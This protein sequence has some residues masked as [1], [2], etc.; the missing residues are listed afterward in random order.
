MP[1]FSV[2]TWNINSVRLRQ[3]LV[4]Q[5]MQDHAP[6][7]VCL[8]E[9]KCLDANFPG[10]AFRKLGYE[11][12][13][14][15]G[16]KG[17]HGVAV[18]SKLPL[19]DPDPRGF[20]GKGDARHLGVTVATPLGPVRIDNFYVPAGGDIPD[21]AVNDKFQHKLDFLKEMT[22][23]IG[24]GPATRPSIVV[25]DLNIAPL[26]DDVWSHKQLLDVVSHTPVETEALEAIRLGGQ[27]IDVLRHHVPTP[28]RLYTWWSY[29]AKDWRAA[30]KGR[31]L[32]HIWASGHFAGQ[33]ESLTVLSEARGWERPS[34]HVPVI[35]RFAAA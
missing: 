6:D 3:D 22:D 29:R 4:G 24:Q 35:A 18:L 5:L 7:V 13:A 32:D 34:D 25:G 9:T 8:Q 27:W 30:N 11:H 20:C 21:P 16:Q 33:L 2:A 12:Q 10:A 23:W 1:R 31:R 19:A 15:N 26:P 17:Y 14:I 28:E